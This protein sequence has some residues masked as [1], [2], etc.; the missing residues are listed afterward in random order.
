MLPLRGLS[1]FVVVLAT[2]I[3]EHFERLQKTFSKGLFT[4]TWPNWTGSE[5]GRNC[6]LPVSSFRF[7]RGDVNGPTQP[8]TFGGTGNE[9]RLKCADALRLG[10]KGRMTHFIC[11][12][13]W[14]GR[15]KLRSSLTPAIPERFRDEYRT[16]YKALY[17]CSVVLY[18]SWSWRVVIVCLF[19]P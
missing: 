15:V 16:H 11:G 12:W 18:L 9:Y 14:S 17:K 13:T 7:C 19:V 3:R 10:S 6:E 2:S 8:P 5:H 1:R 4:L